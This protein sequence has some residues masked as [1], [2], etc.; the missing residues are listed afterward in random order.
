MPLS[1]L[2][3]KDFELSTITS[4][5]KLATRGDWVIDIHSIKYKNNQAPKAC[6][7]YSEHYE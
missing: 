7:L 3:N 4:R 2:D 5:A 6:K 1:C